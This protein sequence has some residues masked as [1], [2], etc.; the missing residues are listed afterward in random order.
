MS[1]W[2]FVREMEEKGDVVTR[3]REYSKQCPRCKSGGFVYQWQV[4]T[5]ED[6]PD[7]RWFCH[8]GYTERPDGTR[9]EWETGK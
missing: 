9:E 3:E 5:F 8:C 1:R 2:Q 6:K 7:E 4:P